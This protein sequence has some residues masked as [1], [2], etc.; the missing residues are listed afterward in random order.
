M[1]IMP[2]TKRGFGKV[3]VI[4][5]V[6]L[7]LVVSVY[8]LLAIDWWPHTNT[9]DGSPTS[10]TSDWKTYK[11]EKNKLEVKYPAN[12]SFRFRGGGSIVTFTDASNVPVTL[13]GPIAGGE[14]FDDLNLVLA[15]H[16]LNIFGKTENPD[17]TVF[18]KNNM[19]PAPELDYINPDL[20]L[21][22]KANRVE[23]MRS[24]PSGSYGGY[25]F[26]RNAKVYILYSL[27]TDTVLAEMIKTFKFQDNSPVAQLPPTPNP[28]FSGC[29]KII[30][31]YNRKDGSSIP[32]KVTLGGKG[33][34]INSHI[35]A[36]DNWAS[37]MVDGDIG[38][39]GKY[40]NSLAPKLGNPLTIKGNKLP[41][42]DT[43]II[44]GVSISLKKIGYTE[45]RQEFAEVC[46][47]S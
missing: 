46:L 7:V 16:V 14:Y 3:W 13:A 47:N 38:P 27:E 30:V 36:E 40:Y 39:I 17:R 34:E 4:V 18:V 42:P 31:S 11:D 8:L 19:S 21:K 5:I 2:N 43:I 12:Y 1:K 33:Y 9:N 26:Q 6:L 10:I 28:V 23:S 24:L 35:E 22:F 37:F 20:A 25:I 44:R 29:E 45:N 41:F 15:V 32:Q